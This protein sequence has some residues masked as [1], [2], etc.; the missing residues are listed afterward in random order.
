MSEQHKQLASGNWQN[1]NFVEQMANIG[2]EVERSIKWRKKKKQ[3]IFEKAAIRAI[4]LIQLTIRA[5]INSSTRLK[6][7]ARLKE[8]LLDDFF[9]DNYYSS[10]DKSWQKYFYYFNYAARAKRS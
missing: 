3:N 2:S 6:E 10:T 9:G 1:L 7:L 8:C 4:E 5:Q